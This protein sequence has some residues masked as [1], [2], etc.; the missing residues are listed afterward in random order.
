MSLSPTRSFH[1]A[2]H[3]RKRPRWSV[4]SPRTPATY[5]R[6]ALTNAT[7]P[8]HPI[9]AAATHGSASGQ[10]IA[11][12]NEMLKPTSKTNV[13]ANSSVNESTATRYDPCCS[14][15]QGGAY[16]KPLDGFG[17]VDGSP[18]ARASKNT[19]APSSA[20]ATDSSA[21]STVSPMASRP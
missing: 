1:T 6:R 8:T 16:I 2:C 9:Q 20:Y 5:Q 13:N 15:H 12:E 18:S 3:T 4:A 11:C 17:W 7:P 14:V 21:F 10:P 19:R